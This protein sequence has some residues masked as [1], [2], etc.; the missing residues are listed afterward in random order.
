[1]IISQ[2]LQMMIKGVQ[3]GSSQYSSL[4]PA[5][6]QSLSH[7]PGARNVVCGADEH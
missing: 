1:M 4:A 7:D 5:A 6:A 3:T 2:S